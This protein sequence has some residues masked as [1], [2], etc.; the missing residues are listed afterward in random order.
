MFEPQI[1]K[2][3]PIFIM[4]RESLASIQTNCDPPQIQIHPLLNIE[5]LPIQVMR[6]ILIH[7]YVHVIVPGIT[8][9]DGSYKSHPPEFWEMERNFSL[10]SRRVWSWIYAHFYDI[11][12][13]DNKAERT[14]VKRSWRKYQRDYR[15]QMELDPTKSRALAPNFEEVD[16]DPKSQFDLPDDLC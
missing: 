5:W 6:H 7:E 12:D 13:R 9:E 4:E 1:P 16:Q 10:E 2:P 15:A 11:L 8:L 3:L 14:V